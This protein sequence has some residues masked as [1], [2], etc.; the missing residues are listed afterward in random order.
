MNSVSMLQ[1]LPVEKTGLPDALTE[2]EETWLRD[3]C[4]ELEIVGSDQISS[5]CGKGAVGKKMQSLL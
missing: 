2:D 1:V 4:E 3:S 5:L